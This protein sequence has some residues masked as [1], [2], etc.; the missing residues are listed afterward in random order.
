M[1]ICIDL[2]IVLQISCGVDFVNIGKL[3]LS[4]MKYLAANVLKSHVRVLKIEK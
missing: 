3:S 4:E 2:S 1:D